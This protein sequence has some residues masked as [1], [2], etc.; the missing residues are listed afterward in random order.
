[1]NTRTLKN[2]S[3]FTLLEVMAAV[4]ILAMFLVP[5]LGAVSGGM[6][7][8]EHAR[9]LQV[10]RQLAANKLEELK[11]WKIPE[12]EQQLDG[13]FSPQYPQYRY[14]IIFSKN[15]TLQLLEQQIAGLKT[16][17]VELELSWFEGG[18]ERTL[19]FQ[20]ILAK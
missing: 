12:A 9:N 18:Q 10:A 11:V 20:T 17:E 7:A 13:D 8:I 6:R 5:L 1:M 19:Q 4:C 15:P 2:N 14:R 16:M 3:A